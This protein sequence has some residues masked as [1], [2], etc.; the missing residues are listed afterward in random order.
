MRVKQLTQAVA[1]NVGNLA[2]GIL[3]QAA[4]VN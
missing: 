1:A 4:Q 3:V 2:A